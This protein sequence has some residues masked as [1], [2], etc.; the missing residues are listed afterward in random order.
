MSAQFYQLISRLAEEEHSQPSRSSSKKKG[1]VSF[2]ASALSDASSLLTSDVGKTKSYG[3][4]MQDEFGDWWW[5]AS[6]ESPWGEC[7]S[8]R[9]R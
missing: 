7:S 9:G 2:L 4:V 6:E 3:T 8:Y 5:A 1:G